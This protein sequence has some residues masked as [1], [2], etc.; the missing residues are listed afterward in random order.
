MASCKV[1][2]VSTL[3]LPAAWLIFVGLALPIRFTN[4]YVDSLL[5]ES[6]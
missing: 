2:V 3:M 5:R 4:N 6:S 1:S